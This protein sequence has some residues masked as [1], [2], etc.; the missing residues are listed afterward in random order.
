MRV[1]CECGPTKTPTKPVKPGKLITVCDPTI[2]HVEYPGSCYKFRH[3]QPTIDGGWEYAIKTCG[4]SMMYNPLSMVCDHIFNVVAMK[5]ECGGRSVD[6]DSF[7]DTN[8]IPNQCPPGFDWSECAVPC[9]RSCMYYGKLLIKNGLCKHSSNE[10]EPGCVDKAFRMCKH[11]LFWR[12]QATCVKV[13]DCTCMSHTGQIV[14]PG[15][16]I[17]E[18]E[19]EV[20][21][22]L[23]N[24]Y[25]CDKSK[26]TTSQGNDK[27][28]IP[29][30]R[31]NDTQIVIPTI[32]KNDTK[33]VVPIIKYNE[34]KVVIPT[35]NPIIIVP[36]TVAPPPKCEQHRFVPMLTGD[37]GLPDSAFK[38]SSILSNSYKPHN[39][40]LNMKP[41]ADSAGA[42]APLRND[43]MEYLQVTF[44]KPTPLFGVII[45]GSPIVD[46][47]VTMFKIMYSLDGSVFSHVREVYEDRP[48]LFYGPI[49]SRTP[50]ES[51]FFVPIEAKVIRIYPITWHEGI[52]IRWELLGCQTGK[53]PSEPISPVTK[54]P[55]ITMPTTPKIVEVVEQ[56]MCDDPMGLDNGKMNPPQVVVSSQK[57]K[58][59]RPFDLLKLS[60]KTGWIPNLSSPNEYIIFDFLGKRNLTGLIT[61][62]GSHGYVT[63]YN[64]FYSVDRT[65]WNPITDS[66]QTIRVFR[67]NADDQSAKVNYFKKPIQAQYLKVVPIKWID[68]IVMK[69]EPVGCF[70]PYRE[71][72]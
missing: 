33:I 49:D 14:K 19:C 51:E 39:S 71:Y 69:V 48:Q 27:I 4:P 26:C 62:G 60:S 59:A 65:F 31:K 57:D 20:C 3:C 13:A 9:R 61:K 46:N 16:V 23:D 29:I 70:K 6:Q 22:C 56:P 68:A 72:S 2:P 53:K 55:P 5:P 36:S 12:D 41:S 7:E 30:I 67:G 17:K 35:V 52:A 34:T 66:D 43:D 63:A 40:R 28:V 44:G 58:Q 32:H 24:A 54:P 47:Y 15:Q 42:W 10:C 18:S 37:L 8:E 1:Y 38:A 25:V 50:I 64:V 11:G 21:Q 45:Q